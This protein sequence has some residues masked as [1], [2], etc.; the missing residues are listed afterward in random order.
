[1]NKT[2][3]IYGVSKGLGKAMIEGLAEPTDRVYGV[4]RT[5]PSA[6]HPNF[7]WIKADLATLTSAQEIKHVIKDEPIDYLIY[8]VGIWESTAFTDQYRFEETSDIETINMIQTNITSCILNLK[9]MLANLKK[10]PNAKIILI[11]ST[12][13]LDN[14]NGQEVTFS[15]TKYALRGVVQSLRESLRQDRIGISIV[16]LGYLATE[17]PLEVKAEEIIA[18]THGTLIPLSDVLSAIRFILNTSTAC[19]VKEIDMPAMM[20]MNV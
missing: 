6:S 8:N 3:L 5:E 9:M 17:Y 4:S 18:Q 15:A 14:H 2:F 19:C 20:D 12:W 16:N 10:S 11:G 13:G 7:N 1:M